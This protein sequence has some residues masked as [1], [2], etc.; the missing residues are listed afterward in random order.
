[1]IFIKTFKGYED[2][3]QIIDKAV[4]DW[5]LASNADVIDVKAVLSHEQE[6]RAR[7]GDLV[8]VVLYRAESPIE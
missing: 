5:I 7:S 1:M 3:V 6:S 8:Y 4:N 2:K